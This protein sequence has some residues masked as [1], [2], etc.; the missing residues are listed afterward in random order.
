M[1]SAFFLIAHFVLL[2]SP[3]EI[4]M[5]TRSASL[6]IAAA[7]KKAVKKKIAKKSTSSSLN[8]AA[9][10]KKSMRTNS[11]PWFSIFT[12]GDMEYNEYMTTEWGFE[13]VCSKMIKYDFCISAKLAADL[14]IRVDLMS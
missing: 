4:K 14:F 9:A 3:K 10:S 7:T 13:K 2:L 12:K 11:S 1:H 5:K 8:A 6:V